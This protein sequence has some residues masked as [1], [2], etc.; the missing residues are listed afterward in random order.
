MAQPPNVTLTPARQRKVL[1]LIMRAKHRQLLMLEQE[2]AVRRFKI[3]DDATE[4]EVHEQINDCFIERQGLE[5]K[6]IAVEG[7]GNIPFPSDEE[8][9]RLAEAVGR[10]D[11]VSL[12][13]ASTKDVISAAHGLIGT[14][15]PKPPS[16]A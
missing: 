4:G 9:N 16:P 10:L 13:T 14:F 11:H 6:I 7:T 8:I 12:S 5:A 2:L 3:D 1:L 15:P